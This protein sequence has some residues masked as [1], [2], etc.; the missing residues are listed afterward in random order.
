MDS[1]SDADAQ[2]PAAGSDGGGT[3]GQKPPETRSEQTFLRTQTPLLEKGTWQFDVGAAYLMTEFDFPTLSGTD[4]VRGELRRRQMIAPLA[5][6]YG[7]TERAQL[8]CNAPVGWRHNQIATNPMTDSDPFDLNDVHVGIGDL[9]LGA[10]Y[11]ARKSDGKKQSPDVV[12]TF[13]AT[14]PT[15]EGLMPVSVLQG[16]LGTG[17]ASLGGQAL[18]IHNYDPAVVFW[19]VGYRHSFERSFS[20]IDVQ[21][22]EE[23]SAQL[24]VGFAVNDRVTLSTS[25]LGGFITETEFNGQGIPNSFQESHRA[26]FAV[27]IDQE[28]RI[29]EPFV[30]IGMTQQSPMT[31]IG[32]V[33]TYGRGTKSGDKTTDSDR[34]GGK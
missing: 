3:Y 11:L 12:L 23:F 30:E 19:G 31:H 25:Y 17:I 2:P 26:R 13:V 1:P 16:G 6:R 9:Q 4:I 8:F 10:S 27:T 14:L 32:V 34:A 28:C 29:L 18:V 7:L 24:G 33:W 5:L 22:G 21:V 20:G 15:G